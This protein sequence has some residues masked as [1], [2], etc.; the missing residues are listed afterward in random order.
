M[1]IIEQ[2]SCGGVTADHP[3]LPPPE[4]IFGFTYVSFFIE[5]TTFSAS[6][7]NAVIDLTTPSPNVAAL[8]GTFDF[9]GI[10]PQN[11]VEVLYRGGWRWSGHPNV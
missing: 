8:T 11:F 2:V 7:H 9:E 4:K 6:K 1:D 10:L 5:K 3:L